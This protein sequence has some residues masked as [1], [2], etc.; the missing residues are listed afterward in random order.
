MSVRTRYVKPARGGAAGRKRGRSL[1]PSQGGNA[2]CLANASE[3]ALR[4]PGSG[5]TPSDRRWIACAECAV[6]SAG[7]DRKSG[8]ADR[9]RRCATATKQKS[10]VRKKICERIFGDLLRFRPTRLRDLRAIAQL[11]PVRE[12]A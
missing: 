12:E 2:G 9:A 8:V 5:L 6:F 4:L 7:H 10:R 1:G 11:L 3:K